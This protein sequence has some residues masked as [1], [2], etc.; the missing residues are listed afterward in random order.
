MKG[1]RGM[2]VRLTVY[3]LLGREVTTLVNQQLQPGVYEVELNATNYTSGVYFYK[4]TSGD[5]A[6]TKRMVLIK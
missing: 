4:L 1:V 2:S 6:D 3:D 5:F